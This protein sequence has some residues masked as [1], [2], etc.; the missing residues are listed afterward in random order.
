VE[1]ILTRHKG[2]GSEYQILLDRKED[3]KDYMTIRVE[4][5]PGAN[6]EGDASLGKDIGVDLRKSLLVS[7]IIEIVDYGSLPRTGR[8]SQR[9]F[10]RRG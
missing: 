6:P 4:R 3:G 7:G 5:A 8:K 1:E 2:I 9:L 10:D